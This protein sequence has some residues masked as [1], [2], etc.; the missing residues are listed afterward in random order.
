M[1][2]SKEPVG[3]LLLGRHDQYVSAEDVKKNK[4]PVYDATPLYAKHSPT[5]K[6]IAKIYG[7]D[8]K[9]ILSLI[10]II[11]FLLVM[12]FGDQIIGNTIGY[13]NGNYIRD[14]TIF[15]VFIA[16]LTIFFCYKIYTSKNL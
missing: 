16:S 1:K 10:T 2:Y 12:F 11:G 9:T 14:E 4:I 5:K 3:Y 7:Y 15:N 13:N 6:E 8:R